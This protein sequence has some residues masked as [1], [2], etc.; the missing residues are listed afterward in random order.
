MRSRRLLMGL[1]FAV[2]AMM[3]AAAGAYVCQNG[4]DYQTS[5]GAGDNGNICISSTSGCCRYGKCNSLGTCVLD[6]NP[7]NSC[8]PPANVCDQMTCSPGGTSGLDAVCT[9]IPDPTQAGHS[10]DADGNACTI[11]KCDSSSNCVFDHNK[12]CSINLDPGCTGSVSC[13]TSTG[14]CVQTY[15]N[16]GAACDDGSDC[17]TGEYCASGNCGHGSRAP[18]G[19][20]CNAYNPCQIGY[21]ESNHDNCTHLTNLAN[22]TVCGSVSSCVD[23][24]CT[25]GACNTN[26]NKADGTVCGSTSNP[27]VDAACSSGSCTGTANKANGTAC[28]TD[29]NSCTIQTCASGTCTVSS[30]A[31]S[32]IVC[33]FCDPPI[34]CG[35]STPACGCANK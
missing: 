20:P 31:V 6:S 34:A 1:V 23:K 26:T 9:E 30:C 5:C 25:S 4:R 12:S 11:D 22:G 18:A 29:T 16:E 13:D 2:A 8:D 35:T 21:C 24:T 15:T 27:C 3:P 19:T 32:P 10:C 7:P 17:T 28:Q 14:N 33:D